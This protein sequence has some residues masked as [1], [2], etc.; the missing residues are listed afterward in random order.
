M[1][2]LGSLPPLW[3]WWKPLPYIHHVLDWTSND[4][5]FDADNT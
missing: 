1:L 3:Q 2:A 4:R 5:D